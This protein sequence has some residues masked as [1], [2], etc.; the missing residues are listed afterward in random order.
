MGS[1]MDGNYTIGTQKF[2]EAGLRLGTPM[3]VPRPRHGTHNYVASV[4]QLS[5]KDTPGMNVAD[6]C[7]YWKLCW[8]FGMFVFA[9]VHA[10]I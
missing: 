10:N 7:T 5:T 4:W 8:R 2:N 9:F 1:D 6:L 3:E